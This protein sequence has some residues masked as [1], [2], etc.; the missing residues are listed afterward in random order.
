VKLSHFAIVK[1]GDGTE[2]F[3]TAVAESGC[4]LHNERT[5]EIKT[6]MGAVPRGRRGKW[7][8]AKSRR[9][10]Q[11]AAEDPGPDT[12]DPDQSLRCDQP[13]RLLLSAL[14]YWEVER[15][16]IEER[17]AATRSAPAAS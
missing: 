6:V 16:L 15:D 7:R 1:T 10:L 8:R 12:L 17:L 3:V 13:D 14:K 5:K 4:E 2:G 9:K 11:R